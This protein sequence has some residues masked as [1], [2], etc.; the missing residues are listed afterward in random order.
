MTDA[1]VDR[2]QPPK[3]TVSNSSQTTITDLSEDALAHCAFYLRL[4][5]VSNLAVTCK[6]L[7]RVAYSD[8]I[9]HCLFREHWPKEVP[10]SSSQTSRGLREAYLSRHAA[11]QQFKFVDPLTADFHTVARPFDHIV[12]DNNH[13][14]FSQGSSI[15]MLNIDGF[16][17]GMNSVAALSDH[18]ARI[19][20]MRLFPLTE[21]SLVRSETRRKENVLATSS[22][23]R[24]IR[25]WWKGS[26]QRCLRGHNGPVL[27]LS[28]KLLGDDSA[29]VLAS[30]GEDGTIR[31]WSL[32]STGKRGQH[33]SKATLYG[34]EKPIK[35]MSVAGHRVSLLVTVANDS[36]V[37]VWDTSVSS[38]ARSSCCVGTATVPATPLDMCCYES[39]LYVAAGFSVV[40]IDLRTMQKVNTAAI[41]ES[42][43]CSFTV[44]PSKY[45]ICTGGDGR[46]MLWDTRRSQ[47]KQ[48]PRPLADLDGHTGPVTQLHADPYKI[49]TGGPE[50]PHVN[51]WESD[52]GSQTNSLM[53]WPFEDA[54]TSSCCSAM[55][56]KG[57]QIIT[58]SYNEDFG[59]VRFRDFSNASCPVPKHEGEHSSKF[60]D[61]PQSY[62]TDR[63]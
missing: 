11:V 22:C 53:C 27:T 29:K 41:G 21:T 4:Q 7:K 33:A 24:S 42:K 17:G 15:R 61:H 63:S 37:R 28:D 5:D 30:G 25:L 20:C 58:T 54:G 9:W 18:N 51:V 14:F 46:A 43:L 6:S 10:Q 31:L 12:L 16:L 38:G 13:I 49:V 40:T 8:S 62:D 45:L 35:L 26:C 57:A 59:V 50:D 47:E 39:L 2:S 34:H 55:A 32:S 36:K 56:V 60:W 1:A 48:K 19:T 23:D 44:L 3:P 52:T